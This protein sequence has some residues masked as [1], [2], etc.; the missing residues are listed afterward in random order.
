MRR[1]YL[2]FAIVLAATACLAQIQQ[3]NRQATT[4]VAAVQE[5]SAGSRARASVSSGERTLVGCVAIGAPSGYV[6]KTDDGN[7]VN[8]R[9]VGSD[10]SAYV[11]KRVE[12]HATWDASGVVM[13]T[14]LETAS[15]AAAPGAGGKPATDFAGDLHLRFK[16]KVVG[17]CLGKK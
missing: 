15:G 14:P 2:T 6:L 8:L 13:S 16:G 7:T 11:G 10:L 12:I 4:T 5:P 1:V 17:D 3:P 9:N